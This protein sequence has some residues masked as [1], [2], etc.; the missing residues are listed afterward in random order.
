MSEARAWIKRAA[1]TTQ[2]APARFDSPEAALD[3][4]YKVYRAGAV[5]VTVVEGGDALNL[6]LPADAELRA[7]VIE[8]CN[9]ERERIGMAALADEG[10]RDVTL[11]W[12]GVP[13]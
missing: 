13:A 1:P 8:V 7:H 11:S 4:V 9:V 6:V 2:F 12:D 3:F 10:Q 5:E